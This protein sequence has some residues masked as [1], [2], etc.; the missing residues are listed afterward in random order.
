MICPKGG[1]SGFH[2]V[3]VSPSGEDNLEDNFIP[4]NDSS[5][6]KMNIFPKIHQNKKSNFLRF[7]FFNNFPLNVLKHNL[8]FTICR[9][10]KSENCL[11][12]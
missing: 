7:R 9:G 11:W 5:Y 1:I 8:P 12:G 2:M 10:L 4:T 3:V 6:L